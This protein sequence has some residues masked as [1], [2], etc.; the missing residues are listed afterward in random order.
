MS[1]K[2]RVTVAAAVLALSVSGCAPVTEQGTGPATQ[3]S[4]T[5]T[6]TP[7]PTLTESQ[8]LAWEQRAASNPETLGPGDGE[9]EYAQA[10]RDFPLEMPA[11]TAIP[12]RTSF[13]F[14]VAD[15]IYERGMG[16]LIVS[17]TWLCA[18]ETAL[19]DALKNAD[20]TAVDDSV[21]RL[22]AWMSLPAEIRRNEGIEQF[23]TVVLETA[24]AGDTTALESDQNSWCAQFPFEP[25]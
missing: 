9:E 15:G 7:S 8:L 19:L 22:K 16:A 25:A 5:A 20:A 11:G 1:T 14:Y 18:T 4:Q 10:R 23:G 17:H 24:L 2:A 6:P 3:H 13:D 12:A 21:A